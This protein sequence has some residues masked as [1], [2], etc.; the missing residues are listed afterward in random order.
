MKKKLLIIGGGFAGC[1][2]A[3]LFSKLNNWE[4]TIIEKNNF[5]GDGV[6]TNWYGGHP[7][8]FGPRHFLTPYD[9]VYKY[10]NEIIPLRS[11]AE[12]EFLTQFFDKAEWK[13]EN[14]ELLKQ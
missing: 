10:L 1:C 6:R 5:L 11:C 13:N 9:N 12:H 14:K 4:T 7:Y 3:H 8:T 2:V